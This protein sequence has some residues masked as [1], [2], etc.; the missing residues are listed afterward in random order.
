MSGATQTAS[1]GAP[2]AAIMV[3][4][5]IIAKLGFGVAISWWWVFAP[6]WLPLVAILGVTIIGVVLYALFVGIVAVISFVGNRIKVATQ[7]RRFA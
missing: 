7:R 1:K 6:L 4:A 5:L 3:V 2:W